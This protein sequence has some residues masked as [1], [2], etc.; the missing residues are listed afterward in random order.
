MPSRIVTGGALALLVLAAGAAAAVRLAPETPAAWHVDPMSADVGPAENSWRATPE[1]AA[2]TPDGRAPLYSVPP[3]ELAVAFD[4]AVLA[5]PR[6]ERIAGDPAEGL[7]TYRQRS[8]VFG[9]PDYISVRTLPAAGG[10]T[11]A[12]WSRSRFGKSDLG[13]NAERVSTWLELLKPLEQ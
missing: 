13:V 5:Q 7:T 1:G 10:S 11:L 2:G 4:A 3:D 6:V 9:F 8:L 12:I